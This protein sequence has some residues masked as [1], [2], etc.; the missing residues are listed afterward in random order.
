MSKLTHLI[1][2]FLFHVFMCVYAPY[3][4]TGQQEGSAQETRQK[5]KYV[6]RY[7]LSHFQVLHQ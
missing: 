7:Q 5:S 1:A 6:L 2:H 4:C 3:V